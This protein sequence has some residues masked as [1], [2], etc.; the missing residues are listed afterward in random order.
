MNVSSHCFWLHSEI[1]CSFSVCVCIFANFGWSSKSR[2]TFRYLHYFVVVVRLRNWCIS[3][4]HSC[5]CCRIVAFQGMTTSKID[6]VIVTHYELFD[7]EL[8]FELHSAN[9]IMMAFSSSR[10]IVD[11]RLIYVV[12]L[13][14]LLSRLF[15]FLRLCLSWI[16]LLFFVNFQGEHLVVCMCKCI[17]EIRLEVM[18]IPIFMYP[19]LVPVYCTV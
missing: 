10:D 13:L 2:W 17:N 15:F 8:H 1:A 14:L 7:T 9:E 3:L 5:N 11:A 18:F 12:L 6:D 16:Y 4:S 19:F